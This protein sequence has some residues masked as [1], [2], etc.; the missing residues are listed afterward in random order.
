MI[1]SITKRISE[2][3]LDIEQSLDSP[4]DDW[5]RRINLREELSSLESQA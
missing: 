3:K 5:Q 4:F 1:N 2:I